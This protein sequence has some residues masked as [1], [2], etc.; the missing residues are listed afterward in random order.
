MVS[1]F[2][3]PKY[4]LYLSKSGG[5]GLSLCLQAWMG[6]LDDD[7]TMG[8]DCWTPAKDDN[9]LMA[10]LVYRPW[11]SKLGSRRSRCCGSH[12]HRGSPS[13]SG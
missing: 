10:L 2:T 9:V 6:D 11:V 5:S 13:P 12:A 1:V 7:M 8:T 3:Q 4:G